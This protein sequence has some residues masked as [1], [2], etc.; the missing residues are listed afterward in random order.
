[1]YEYVKRGT[2]S[3][4]MKELDGNKLP[5]DLAKFYAAEIVLTLEYLH[6]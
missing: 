1:M 4:F 5:L 3:K 6:S 2:L